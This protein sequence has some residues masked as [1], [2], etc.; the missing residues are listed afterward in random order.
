[1]RCVPEVFQKGIHPFLKEKTAA[2]KSR[3]EEN[4][5]CSIFCLILSQPGVKLAFFFSSLSRVFWVF[6]G[7]SGFCGK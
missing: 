7:F 3:A 4:K 5:V 6:F 1:M 2:S